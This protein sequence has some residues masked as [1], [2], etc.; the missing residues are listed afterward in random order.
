VLCAP[1]TTRPCTK[2]TS[3]ISWQTF[4]S[5]WHKSR[6]C[7]CTIV[8]SSPTWETCSMAC[9]SSRH[10]NFWFDWLWFRFFGGT[11]L[12]IHCNTNTLQS[13]VLLLVVCVLFDFS[14]V[15]D[16]FFVDKQWWESMLVISF[17]RQSVGIDLRRGKVRPD[18]GGKSDSFALNEICRGGLEN[19]LLAVTGTTTKYWY[20]VVLASS[21]CTTSNTS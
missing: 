9:M 1:T 17:V 7:S 5:V 8:N 21:Y 14:F 4:H 15:K 13:S 6:G 2:V 16:L 18:W 11:I 20:G 3:W 19:A 10:S 12:I